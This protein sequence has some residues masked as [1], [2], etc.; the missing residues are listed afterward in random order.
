MGRQLVANALV[1]NGTRAPSANHAN[2]IVSHS[3]S[4]ESRPSRTTQ[5][6]EPSGEMISWTPCGEL[7][8]AQMAEPLTRAIGQS[9][10]S[11]IWMPTVAGALTHCES[12][13]T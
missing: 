2:C 8:N 10:T 11:M 9:L 5:P 6:F 1:E 13:A 4:V 12:V 7:G 3:A